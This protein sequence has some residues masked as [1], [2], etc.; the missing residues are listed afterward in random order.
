MN[1][2]SVRNEISQINQ[3][4]M[5]ISQNIE[6]LTR[7]L[8]NVADTVNNFMV[9]CQNNPG[10]VVNETCPK[11]FSE[12]PNNPDLCV[13]DYATQDDKDAI[14]NEPHFVNNLEDHQ[15][16]NSIG[17][18]HY[19]RRAGR[20]KVDHTAEL[21]TDPIVLAVRKDFTGDRDRLV[22]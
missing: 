21:D 18:Y 13:F 3:S 4:L 1:T 20:F 9:V 22:K 5:Q 19:T 17:P 2:E 10:E 14:C 8:Q 15:V 16:V 6:L 7:A 11:F 12:Y